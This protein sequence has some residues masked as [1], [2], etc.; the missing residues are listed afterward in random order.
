MNGRP[1]LV[2]GSPDLVNGSPD[3]V[4]GSS[5]WGLKVAKK[6]DEELNLMWGTRHNPGIPIYGYNPYHPK[7]AKKVD[8]ELNLMWAFLSLFLCGAICFALKYG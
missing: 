7:V 2:N 6:V 5:K 8:E 1:D 4:N 3:L